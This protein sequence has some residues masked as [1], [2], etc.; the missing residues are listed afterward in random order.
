MAWERFPELSHTEGFVE[1]L[2]TQGN[3]LGFC[4][5][6]EPDA[7]L[8]VTACL[9]PAGLLHDLAQ[10]GSQAVV[11]AAPGASVGWGIGLARWD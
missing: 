5:M 1:R 4:L 7:P 8:S 9:G 2:R 11:A 6:D 3:Q 10:A